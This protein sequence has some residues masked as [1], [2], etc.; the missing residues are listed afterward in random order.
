MGKLSG[1]VKLRSLS[2][3]VVGSR[4]VIWRRTAKRNGNFKVRRLLSG[5]FGTWVK[6]ALF[7]GL[8]PQRGNRLC[9]EFCTRELANILLGGKIAALRRDEGVLFEE[10]ATP[11]PLPSSPPLFPS[12]PAGESSWGCKPRGGFHPSSA[13]CHPASNTFGLPRARDMFNR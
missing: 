12:P 7:A 9:A 6:G 5:G 4:T 3:I 8:G 2:E 13:Q 1:K 11:S 10:S